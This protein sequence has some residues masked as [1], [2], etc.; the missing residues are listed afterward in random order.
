MSNKSAKCIQHLSIEDVNKFSIS[1][2]SNDEQDINNIWFDINKDYNQLA[3]KLKRHKITLPV[4]PESIYITAEKRITVDEVEKGTDTPPQQE[5]PKDEAPKTPEQPPSN[6]P[7][8]I[9]ESVNLDNNS[10]KKVEDN[11]SSKNKRDSDAKKKIAS[12]TAITEAQQ[13]K[14]DDALTEILT[15]QEEQLSVSNNKIYHDALRKIEQV[16]KQVNAAKVKGNEK[17]PFTTEDVYNNDLAL[18]L[19]NEAMLKFPEL[20]DTINKNIIGKSKTDIIDSII[21]IYEEQGHPLSNLDLNQTVIKNQAR[22]KTTSLLENTEEE[23]KE[24]DS[25]YDA[26][27]AATDIF[28]PSKNKHISEV[29]NTPDIINNI[30]KLN[31]TTK[32]V[33]TKLLPLT[34]MIRNYIKLNYAKSDFSKNTKQDIVNDPSILLL[35]K[36][37]QL[38]VP[39]L[40]A[41]ALNLAHWIVSSN[42]TDTLFNDKGDTNAIL[43]RKRKDVINDYGVQKIVKGLGSVAANVSQSLGKDI[44][45]SL[46]SKVSANTPLYFKERLEKALGDRGLVTLINARILDRNNINNSMFSILK[47]LAEGRNLDPDVK[48]DD[49]LINFVRLRESNQKNKET[50]RNKIISL[51]IPKV[52]EDTITEDE[53]L[54]NETKELLQQQ[55]NMID[56]GSLQELMKEPEMKE[57]LKNLFGLGNV[58]RD[59]S[60]EPITTVQKKL[61]NSTTHVPVPF[62]NN[63]MKAT[64]VKWQLINNADTIINGV[65]DNFFMDILEAPRG[66]ELD[67]T[68]LDLKESEESKTENLAEEVSQL[69]IFTKTNANELQRIFYYPISIWKNFRMGVDSTTINAQASKLHRFL[70]QAV[71]WKSTVDL[72]NTNQDNKGFQSL[73]WAMAQGLDFPIDKAPLATT[74]QR[75][76]TEVYHP[77]TGFQDTDKGRM[78]QQGVEL[79]KE[80][81][82]NKS[83][84]KSQENKLAESVKFFGTKTHAYITLK[85]LADYDN[86][87]NSSEVKEFSHYLPIE[88]DGVTNGTS[89]SLLLMSPWTESYK[90]KLNAVG[91]Y[92]KEDEKPDGSPMD[93]L[94]WRGTEGNKDNYE[95]LADVANAKLENAV[96]EVRPTYTD[97]IA[98]DEEGN[99]DR[100][101]YLRQFF[102]ISEGKGKDA[103]N[104]NSNKVIDIIERKI[105]AVKSLIGIFER[106]DAKDPLM[107]FQYMASVFSI[108]T[109]FGALK[110]EKM[111]KDITATGFELLDAIEAL[112]TN[113]DSEEKTKLE[114]AIIDSGNKLL[115]TEIALVTLQED[116]FGKTPL[117]S[118]LPKNVY[119]ARDSISSKNRSELVNFY[120]TKL[121]NLKPETLLSEIHWREITENKRVNN[122][123]AFTHTKKTLTS[124]SL[125]VLSE[126]FREEYGTLANNRDILNLGANVTN[127]LFKTLEKY[128]VQ[129]LKDKNNGNITEQQYKQMHQEMR[130]NGEMLTIKSPVSTDVGLDNTNSINKT[131][132]HISNFTKT[133]VEGNM[134]NVVSRSDFDMPTTSYHMDIENPSLTSITR[135]ESTTNQLGGNI[136][137]REYSPNLG[138]TSIPSAQIPLDAATNNHVMGKYDM[139]GVHDAA[140]IGAMMAHTFAP[141]YNNGYEKHLPWD[142]V[143]AFRDAAVR[144]R[145]HFDELNLNE[146]QKQEVKE[147]IFKNSTAKVQSRIYD[148]NLDEILEYAIGDLVSY[149]EINQEHRKAR[150]S[151]LSSRDQYAFQI[152]TKDLNNKT[153]LNPKQT[154]TG[155]PP[156]EANLYEEANP[157]NFMRSTSTNPITRLARNR[158]R[159]ALINAGFTFF[160][161]NR[162]SVAKIENIASKILHERPVDNEVFFRDAAMALSYVFFNELKLEKGAKINNLNKRLWVENKL[163]KWLSTG[164]QPTEHRNLW[165]QVK[166][167]YNKLITWFGSSKE[168]DDISTDLAKLIRKI[169]IRDQFRFEPAEGTAKMSFQKE[170]TRNPLAV[171]VLT[172]FNRMKLPYILTGSVAYADQ[173][174]MYRNP[175]KNL[176]DL[177]FLFGSVKHI[178]KAI[179]HLEDDLNGDVQV[180]YFFENQI[181]GSYT[182][183]LAFVPDGYEIRDIKNETVPIVK[184]SYNVYSKKTGKVVGGYSYV[185]EDKKLGVKGHESFKK[186]GLS[187]KKQIPGVMIDLMLDPSNDDGGLTRKGVKQSFKDSQGKEHIIPVST[188]EAGFNAKLSMLRV[189]DMSDFR[190]MEGLDPA[191]DNRQ[192]IDMAPIGENVDYDTAEYSN[193]DEY[194]TT[195]IES[196]FAIDDPFQGSSS[197]SAN[198]PSKFRQ[199]NTAKQVFDV[200]TI[201]TVFNDLV[202]NQVGNVVENVNHLQ[203]LN[204][205]LDEILIPAIGSSNTFNLLQNNN[206][207]HTN[208]SGFS[209]ADT[210]TI[211]MD[212][213]TPSSPTGLISGITTK[214]SSSEVFTHEM[215]HVLMKELINNNPAIRNSIA[216]QYRLAKKNTNWENFI[217]INPS[218]GKP[219]TDNV[220]RDQAKEQYEYIFRTQ[221]Q[222]KYLH[223]FATYA[224][225]NE[226][227]I[228]HLGTLDARPPKL[229]YEGNIF[230][231]IYAVTVNGINWL[232]SLINGSHNKFIDR[233][234]HSIMQGAAATNVK[235]LSRLDAGKQNLYNLTYLSNQVMQAVGTKYIWEPYVDFGTKYITSLENRDSKGR[236]L[237]RIKNIATG[238]LL[239]PFYFSHSGLKEQLNLFNKEQLNISRGAWYFSFLKEITG[240]NIWDEPFEDLFSLK[241][242]KVDTLK[243]NKT[244]AVKNNII[245]SFDPENTITDEVWEAHNATLL[246]TDLSVFYDT[247]NPDSINKIVN[248]LDN[249]V[250]RNKEI[251]NL[252]SQIENTVTK[253]EANMILPQIESL[254]HYTA[255]GIIGLES[256]L[257]NATMI[258]LF[259]T[260]KEPDANLVSMIDKLG[261]LYAVKYTDSNDLKL[262]LENIKHEQARSLDKGSLNGIQNLLG[263]HSLFKRDTLDKNFKGNPTLTQK[264]YTKENFDSNISMK[265]TTSLQGLELEK[266]G[267]TRINTKPLKISS[268]ETTTGFDVTGTSLQGFYIYVSNNGGLEP[269]L[270]GIASLTSTQHKGFNLSEKTLEASGGRMSKTAYQAIQGVNSTFG[271]DIRNQRNKRTALDFN[272]KEGRLA[273]SFDNNNNIKSYRY[274][275]SEANKKT[276]LGKKD[277][278]HDVLA[279]MFGS[280]IDKAESPHFNEELMDLLF[281]DY[282]VTKDKLHKDDFIT[283]DKDNEFYKLLP[284]SVKSYINNTIKAEELPYTALRV[285]KDLMDIAFGYRKFSM[286]DAL[287]N[288]TDNKLKTM[289]NLM[290]LTGNL[291]QHLV[292]RKK[293][294]I[295]VLNPDVAINNAISN[296]L[297]TSVKGVS[298]DTAIKDMNEGLRGLISYDKGTAKIAELELKIDANPSSIYVSDWKDKVAEIEL[299]LKTNPIMP[300][301]EQG[302]FLTIAEDVE[303]KGTEEVEKT[304]KQYGGVLGKG[305]LSIVDK[306]PQTFKQGYEN[307]IMSSNTE[308]GQFADKVIQYGDFLSRYALWKHRT[309]N[310]N[311]TSQEI[312]QEVLNTFVFYDVPTSKFMQYLNDMG[313][314]M[315][316]KFTFRI[317]RVIGQ[318]IKDA[319]TQVL[320]VELAQRLLTDVS[321]I[322]DTSMPSITGADTID[323]AMEFN[324]YNVT[325]YPFK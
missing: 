280:A 324:L 167:L 325:T 284:P 283:L 312:K 297:L 246:K 232:S 193:N 125:N 263:V 307:A 2:N 94:T 64:Q 194:P 233:M 219:F 316:T 260:L 299:D 39:I 318:V 171:D 176:H 130:D 13:K 89:N 137:A 206:P 145:K 102:F 275:M 141:E 69:R 128:R 6:N 230:K 1:S 272:S 309:K 87:V 114:D 161:T 209:E 21:N 66:K 106:Q 30:H 182:K 204:K 134:G 121:A 48:Q 199:V 212:N 93:Y 184:R 258:G 175:N 37:N 71:G 95:R 173:V 68:N 32:K 236:P 115:N 296:L 107:I 240:N 198:D 249:P 49:K 80:L 124:V 148:L 235:G 72:S 259:G 143:N 262:S 65:S 20:A 210:N 245:N 140:I 288:A 58:E 3:N 60:Y 36:Q 321:D 98:L 92:F 50:G 63:V 142:M 138:A 118:I 8:E 289:T 163:F 43:G 11:L 308:P 268:K 261:T 169:Q 178:D 44:V 257:F 208:N 322:M 97:L 320:A 70:T 33:M 229:P 46:G 183:G 126:S 67:R 213:A 158:T 221:E 282:E 85:T 201:K 155:T 34:L 131:D 153:K 177:D 264:G 24:I 83:L 304:L 269:R 317:I 298:P 76:L 105:T 234:M 47:A 203:H 56:L 108:A 217:P 237:K 165:Y 310:S 101:K 127:V 207:N 10:S 303:Q 192:F 270:S 119:D 35:N 214:M 99:N 281:A 228:K 291:W 220:S 54:S 222:S 150:N 244:I 205:I 285:R 290:R 254:G 16:I 42:A 197:H 29:I 28:I 53:Y 250:V 157:N 132:L 188:Y 287:D 57:G 61:K 218:T 292:A 170:M 86:A 202:S 277:L 12:T 147:V 129:V 144:I 162:V 45:K 252:I 17:S 62:G 225:T 300:L 253:S 104:V 152:G 151:S 154:Y 200:N 251:N 96:N 146:A 224:L 117:L 109:K 241:N 113:T 88:I 256:Q 82:N 267:Y 302:M 295:V 26:L 293:R 231:Q 75:F 103:L 223:E 242:Q 313:L 7:T 84:T 112:K 323:K 314:L 51:Q 306:L 196:P 156:L 238:L 122:S 168:F 216:K 160:K 110:Y 185:K 187:V 149:N 319:P 166:K 248:Y 255:T 133:I 4:L 179:T 90:L 265:I 59:V 123:P 22:V 14:L 116:L 81:M 136:V 18:N 181:T 55:G 27:P 19:V 31:G 239:T 120:K 172:S 211:F 279:S 195:D 174:P 215:L 274:L 100:L 111:Q 227:F 271:A 40:D 276:I 243:Q 73:L 74:Q 190:G 315:F 294:N 226:Q 78:A 186:K 311:M 5:K 135:T 301:I 273:P 79:I 77:N 286:A 266:Q 247:G 25:R 278:A 52:I 189:K 23:L 191:V 91:T 41:M 139:L 180:V 159:E 15:I 38:P 9:E 164:E 305:V